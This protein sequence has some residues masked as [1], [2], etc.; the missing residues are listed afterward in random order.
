LLHVPNP[1]INVRPSLGVRPTF[2][3]RCFAKLIAQEFEKAG[4]AENKHLS[5]ARPPSN[6]LR[7]FLIARYFR[8]VVVHLGVRL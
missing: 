2:A 6:T 1:T 8:S 3:A 4:Q 7:S 5:V